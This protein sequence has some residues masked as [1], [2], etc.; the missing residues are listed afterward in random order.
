MTCQF[1]VKKDSG[2]GLKKRQG[3][4]EVMKGTISHRESF[5][6]HIQQQLGKNSS[7]T[8][9]IQRPEW[10]HQVQW[11]TNGSLSKEELVEQLKKQCQQIHT[12][13]VETTPEEAPL[14]ITIIDNRIW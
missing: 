9:A 1:Q 7:P 6:S 5:L 4:G 3:G 14:C 12:R 10:R 13:V 8:A 2:I 11:E